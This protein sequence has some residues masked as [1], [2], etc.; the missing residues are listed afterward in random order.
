[1]LWGA[2]GGQDLT[3]APR[4]TALNSALA[5]RNLFSRSGRSVLQ[6]SGKQ[7]EGT[8]PAKRLH[9]TERSSPA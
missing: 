8:L 9:R 3:L 4:K 6:L 2:L 1:M 7:Q 5:F